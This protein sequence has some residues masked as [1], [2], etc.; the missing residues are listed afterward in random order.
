[1]LDGLHKN[2]CPRCCELRRSRDPDGR[3]STVVD[4]PEILYLDEYGWAMQEFLIGNIK[5]KYRRR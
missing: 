3:L 5:K 4:I 1:M 2:A